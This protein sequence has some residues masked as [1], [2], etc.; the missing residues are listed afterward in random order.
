[1]NKLSTQE[2]MKIIEGQL[3]NFDSLIDKMRYLNESFDHDPMFSKHVL[4]IVRSNIAQT[5]C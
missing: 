2:Q 3:K 5:I 4:D 1:M